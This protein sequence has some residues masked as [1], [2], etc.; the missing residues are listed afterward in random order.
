MLYA[1]TKADDD[2]V[3]AEYDVYLTP[4]IQEQIYLL[5]YPNRPRNRPYNNQYGATP[6]DMR[7]KPNSGFLE[8]DVGLNTKHNF[9][10]YQ[11]LK[12]GDATRTSHELHNS[13]GTF[14]L[15][16]GLVYGKPRVTNRGVTL[17]DMG[18]REL[19]LENDLQSF[20]EAEQDNKVHAKQTLGGQI[21]R[22]DAETE[23]GK[24]I[25]F[26][27]AFQGDQLHLTKVTGTVQMRPHFHHLDAEEERNRI[28]V[29]RAHAEANG[30]MPEPVARGLARDKM[31][32]AEKNTVEYKLRMGLQAA[33]MEPWIKMEYVDDEDDL[34]YETFNRTL[35]VEDVT[36]VPHLKSDMDN[37]AFLDAISVPRHDSP[38]RR[39][40][41]APRRNKETVEIEDDE[42]SEAGD[43]E[44]G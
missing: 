12:W 11:G 39:R 44:G 20:G 31:N 32:A 30:P 2:P 5:Q 14:G 23:L 28:S 8:V 16:S 34:A 35:K 13:S 17:R 41:R 40:K 37:D 18:N 10:K 22:H 36:K 15:A 27:G 4:P 7:I 6:H 19:D 21:I 29:A 33:Q 25:Y 24:P 43:E 1:A 3:M 38:T 26:V 42:G 9:N